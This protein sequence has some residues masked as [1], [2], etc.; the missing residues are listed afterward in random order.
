MISTP[1]VLATV[2]DLR[3]SLV[4]HHPSPIVLVPTMGALHDGHLSLVRL[5]QQVK[6]ATVVVSIF[7]NPL[8]FAKGEDLDAYPRTLASDVEKLTALGVDYVFAPSPREVYPNGVRTTVQPGGAADILE[9]ASRPGHFA[10]VLTVV[11]KLFMMTGCTHAV[12]G[13]KDYQQLTLIKQMVAD[14]N[15]PVEIISAPTV[16]EKSGL[17]MSSRN[18]YLSEAE[19]Q[20]ATVLSAALLAGAQHQSVTAITQTARALI[21]AHPDITLDYLE[22]CGTDLGEVVVGTNRLLVAAKVGATRLID[23]IEVEVTEL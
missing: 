10:G 15:I 21:D 17:A 5:A 12:F 20:A 7:V 14:L 8:Q 22:L 1:D 13:E 19:A 6:D 23:N 18:T 9:G 4:A 2:T 16:R 3:Q 11:N